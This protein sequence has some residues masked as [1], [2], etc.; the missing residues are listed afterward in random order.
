MSD[1]QAEGYLEAYEADTSNTLYRGAMEA[2]NFV[3]KKDSKYYWDTQ[4]EGML[5]HTRT[6]RV[7]IN[8]K[9]VAVNVATIRKEY[10]DDIRKNLKKYSMVYYTIVQEILNHPNEPLFIATP[11]VHGAGGAIF[12]SAVL[13]LFGIERALGT[14]TQSLFDTH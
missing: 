13:K 1:T 6:S 9:K 14:S 7:S 3:Y 4:A 2:V 8:G 10:Q 12:L 5:L 11:I